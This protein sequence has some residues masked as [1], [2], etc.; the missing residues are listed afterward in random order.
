MDR[1]FFT[2]KGAISEGWRLTKE[3]LGFLIGYQLILYFVTLLFSGGK[4][5]GFMHD[6]W[7]LLGTVLIFL[8]NMGFYKSSLLIATGIKPEFN[9]LYDNWRQLISWAVASFLFAIMFFIGF[10]LL[11]VPGCYIWAKYGLFP[12]FIVDKKAGPIEALKAAGQATEGV[13]ATLFGFFVICLL[14]NILG[15]LLLGIGLFFTAPTTL[16][17]MA[18]IYRK[19]AYPVQAPVELV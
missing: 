17:A 19:L 3:N 14:L 10:M 9:Q 18:I 6:L 11:I 7:H 2:T 5:F 13:C 15:F 16:I 8:L 4:H 1:K 12:F